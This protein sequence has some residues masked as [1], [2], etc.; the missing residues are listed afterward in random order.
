MRYVVIM[1][2][3]A[4]T[5]LWPMSRA[6]RPK[7]MVDVGGRSLLR[8]SFDRL[9]GVVPA[10]RIHVCTAAAQREPV[11]DELP[12][13]PRGNVLGEPCVR[14]S[15]NAIGFA[16][17]VLGAR[18]PDATIAFVSCDHIIEPVDVFADALRTAF[19][20]VDDRPGALVTCGIV[21]TYAST[22]LG[23]VE[24]GGPLPGSDRAFAVTAFAEKPN[25]LTAEQYLES[26]RYLWNSGTFV[27]RA[28][29]ILNQLGTHLSAAGAGLSRIAAAVDTPAFEA[30]VAEVFP[31]L[32]K[33]SIDYAVMEPA[34]KTGA[35]IVVVPLGVEWLDV[36]T[37]PNLATALG[38]DADRNATQ[39]NSVLLD[40][41][42]NVVV[43]DDPDHLVAAVG[44]TDMVIVHTADATLVVPRAEADRVKALVASIWELYGERYR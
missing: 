35:D 36:G 39:A 16:A 41:S 23:Y 10:E 37:W 17:T 3:G 2:G 4:G 43:S 8:H 30:T 34:S 28:D 5:R 22:A 38:T 13:L 25:Q 21:P 27:W 7:H 6:G 32:P 29:T 11:L 42:G 24:R 9:R 12:E 14:D 26:G 18:D 44:L 20:V 31:D 15:A 1:A 40:S 33:I 19:E